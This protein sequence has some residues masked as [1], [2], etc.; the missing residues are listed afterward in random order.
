MLLTLPFITKSIQPDPAF[1]FISIFFHAYNKYN[2]HYDRV[3]SRLCKSDTECERARE[4]KIYI[5]L[6]HYLLYL[7][8]KNEKRIIANYAKHVYKIN[9]CLTYTHTHAC[10]GFMQYSTIILRECLW[11]YISSLRKNIIK[12]CV[13][14][15][16]YCILQLFIIIFHHVSYSSRA[17]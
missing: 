3:C 13:W 6:L 9:K 15:E 14:K 2:I 1:K 17:M 10:G 11:N 8:L 5:Y 12:I 7:L 16:Y 4:K